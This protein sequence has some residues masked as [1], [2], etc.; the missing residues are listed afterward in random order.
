MNKE[1]LVN[2]VIP[3]LTGDML[4]PDISEA[5]RCIGMNAVLILCRELGGNAIYFPQLEKL[6]APAVREL[7]KKEFTGYNH[8]ELSRK[9]GI[10]LRCVYNYVK[11]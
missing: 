10:S 8:S 1:V 2:N 5:V 3:A 7:V 6:I 9:Y 4:S 11:Q